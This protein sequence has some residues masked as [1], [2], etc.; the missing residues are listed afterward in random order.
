MFISDSAET[1]LLICM[2]Y[3][4]QLQVSPPTYSIW[5]ARPQDMLISAFSKYGQIAFK[6]TYINWHFHEELVNVVP[7]LY[8]CLRAKLLQ[9]C[10]TLCDPMDCSPLGT[11][12]HR[13]LQA[14]IVKWVVI[15]F[16]RGSSWPRNQ[17]CVS[18]IGRWILYHWTTREAPLGLM[19]LCH[20][21]W[22]FCSHTLCLNPFVFLS[23][24]NSCGFIGLTQIALMGLS[25]SGSLT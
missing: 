24:F 2:S 16:S 19:I 25:N 4:W 8:I 12:V 22:C 5:I 3:C 14:R 21:D 7:Y 10:L 11:S 1:N 15:P 23:L 6:R 13:I 17:T 9:S 18:C 20:N